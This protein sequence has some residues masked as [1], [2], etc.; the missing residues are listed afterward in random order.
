MVTVAQRDADFFLQQIGTSPHVRIKGRSATVT[1][2]RLAEVNPRATKRLTHASLA[3][4]NGGP[5][6]VAL[7]AQGE[8]GSQ[9]P[10]ELLEPHFQAIVTV[11]ESIARHLRAGEIAKVRLS[12]A[13]ESIGRHLWKRFELWVGRKLETRG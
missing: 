1:G 5:L 11:T 12:S 13:G 9:D 8:D 2:A 7:V 10:Y 6:A 4:P 3:A